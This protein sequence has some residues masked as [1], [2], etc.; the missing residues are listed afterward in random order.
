MQFGDAWQDAENVSIY[1]NKF[2]SAIKIHDLIAANR[3]LI[4]VFV[5]AV[6]INICLLFFLVG[7][8]RFVGIIYTVQE[9]ARFEIP[10]NYLYDPGQMM[11]FSK[12]SQSQSVVNMIVNNHLPLFVGLRR[13]TFNLIGYIAGD[14]GH[15]IHPSVGWRHVVKTALSP[16]TVPL[17]AWCS[18]SVV[19]FGISCLIS[20]SSILGA[21]RDLFTFKGGNIYT[22][23]VRVCER[24]DNYRQVPIDRCALIRIGS[25]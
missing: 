9:R 3:F 15:Q 7:I 5:W 18:R 17:H 8:Y 19:C 13:L 20:F 1:L 25:N 16:I 2:L 14:R 6:N 4:S 10:S 23:C 11:D 12:S 24:N 21:R 22:N